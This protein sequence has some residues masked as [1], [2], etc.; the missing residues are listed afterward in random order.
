[1]DLTPEALKQFIEKPFAFVERIGLK[2]LELKPNYVKLAAPIAGNENHI[3]GMYAGALFT[4]AEI[5]GGALYLTTFDV[6]RFYPIIKEM[7]IRFVAPAKT[8]VTIETHLPEE[9]AYRIEAEAKENGKADYVLEGEVKDAS[10][11]V[12]TVSKGLYQL[13]AF[14]I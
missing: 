6:S 4:L 13:R 14:G 9:E 10:G 11:V 8:D 12:V 5:P 3:G 1:M 2:A 7:T